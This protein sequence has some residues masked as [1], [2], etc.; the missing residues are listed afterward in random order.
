MLPLYRELKPEVSII[1]LAL[2]VSKPIVS[3]LE[4][5]VSSFTPEINASFLSFNELRPSDNLPAPLCN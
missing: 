4:P 2:N 5:S 3:L 1:L